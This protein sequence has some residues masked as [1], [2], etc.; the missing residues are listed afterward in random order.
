MGGPYMTPER[1]KDLREDFKNALTRLK[2]ALGKDPAKNSI[3]VDGT[4][5]RFEFTFEL[6]W[7]LIKSI[8]KYNGIE[9]D[10]PRLAIKE[11]F[12]A[13]MIKDGQG[14]IDMLEDRNKTSHIYDEK[15][16][17]DMYEKIKKN[18]FKL[19]EK[20]DSRISEF[21]EDPH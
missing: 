11:A 18:H 3:M 9:A 1:I 12:A 6:S 2:E 4:I 13:N 10:T 16:A 8:L 15:Q 21:I 5:Q 14:W 17:L 19:L 20:L 7:K